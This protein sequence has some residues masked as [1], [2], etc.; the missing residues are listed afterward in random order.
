MRHTTRLCVAP[1]PG[2]MWSIVSVCW[3]GVG[4][5]CIRN[6][7]YHPQ[8]ASQ[9]ICACVVLH[10][11]HVPSS[12][13]IFHS[14]HFCLEHCCGSWMDCKGA[15]FS[16]KLLNGHF[17]GDCGYMFSGNTWKLR[18]FVVKCCLFALVLRLKLYFRVIFCLSVLDNRPHV[19]NNWAVQLR[20]QDIDDTAGD[21]DDYDAN[22]TDAEV[23]PVT[24]GKQGIAKQARVVTAH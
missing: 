1:G 4:T 22:D 16:Y 18:F 19:I 15:V 10:N 3:N 2:V 17:L 7:E 13:L 20:Q 9:I 8:R 5:A 21:G 12:D 11:C 14:G 23:N 24:G 6:S